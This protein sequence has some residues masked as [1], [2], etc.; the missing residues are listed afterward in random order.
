LGYLTPVEFEAAYYLAADPL[1]G[2]PLA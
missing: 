1:E 2:S